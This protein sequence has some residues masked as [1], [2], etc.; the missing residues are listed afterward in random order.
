[1]DDEKIIALYWARLEKAISETKRKYG[2]YCYAIAYRILR[3]PQDAEECESDTY[4]DV[5]NQ[6]PPTRPT[7]FS[8]F[9]GII[10]RRI[11]LDRFRKLH[12]EKR[13]G[14][15]TA[16]AL[17]ELGECIPGGESVDDHLNGRELERTIRAFLDTLPQREQDIFLNRYFYGRSTAEIGARYAMTDGYVLRL[18]SRIR[19]KLKDYLKKEGYAI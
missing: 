16:L 3:N 17:E 14:G 11:S 7:S 5:W 15:E 19:K 12:A 4:L 6:I 8:T 10:T 2:R 13:G 18:L 1:M 9:L